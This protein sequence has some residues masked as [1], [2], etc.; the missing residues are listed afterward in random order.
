[1]GSFEKVEVKVSNSLNVIRKNPAHLRNSKEINVAE[2]EKVT[3]SV[4]RCSYRDSKRPEY[5]GSYG[6]LK[7]LGSHCE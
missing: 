5:V 6:S 2:V 1:M 7:Y 3:G 4:R